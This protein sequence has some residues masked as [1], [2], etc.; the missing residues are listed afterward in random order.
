MKRNNPSVATGPNVPIDLTSLLDIVFIILFVII[1][2]VERN[3]KDVDAVSASMNSIVS[4]KDN[5]IRNLRIENEEM[6]NAVDAYYDSPEE[7]LEEAYKEAFVRWGEKITII[8]ITCNYKYEYEDAEDIRSNT[9]SVAFDDELCEE[10]FDFQANVNMNEKIDRMRTII[11]RYIDDHPD[12]LIIIEIKGR[13]TV[14]VKDELNKLHTELTAY[15][16]VF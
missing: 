13:Q 16:Q 2:G 7:G 4:E 1:V 14:I 9:M 10:T 3:N 12:R 5:E 8:T 6:K 11:T 15:K